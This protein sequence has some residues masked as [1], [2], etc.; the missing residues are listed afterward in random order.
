MP[1]GGARALSVRYRGAGKTLWDQ[2]EPH[3]HSICT[4]KCIGRPTGYSGCPGRPQGGPP[5]ICCRCTMPI[6]A[7]FGQICALLLAS[8]DKQTNCSWGV[9]LPHRLGYLVMRLMEMMMLAWLHFLH[10]PP[11][12]AAGSHRQHILVNYRK[13]AR[14]YTYSHSYCSAKC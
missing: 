10:P 3:R 8:E 2:F 6:C 1:A 9:C 11:P 4:Y 12:S 5:L 7:V 13:L 14:V